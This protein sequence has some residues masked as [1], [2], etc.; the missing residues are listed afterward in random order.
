MEDISCAPFEGKPSQIA[1]FAADS[2]TSAR[3]L[4]FKEK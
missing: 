2:V 1:T 3:E 4:H